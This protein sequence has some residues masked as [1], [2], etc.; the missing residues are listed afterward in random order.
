MKSFRRSRSMMYLRTSLSSVDDRDDNSVNEVLL[1]GSPSSTG[2]PPSIRRCG[3]L[4]VES[5]HKL[6]CSTGGSNNNTSRGEALMS[7]SDASIDHINS[8]SNRG[9]QMISVDP[10]TVYPSLNVDN[11]DLTKHFV[12]LQYPTRRCEDDA[13]DDA[14][15]APRR[16]LSPSRLQKFKSK[17]SPSQQQQQQHQQSQYTMGEMLMDHHDMVSPHEHMVPPVN[18]V[19]STQ[20]HR[21]DIPECVLIPRSNMNH[22]TTD[23]FLEDGSRCQNS[24]ENG[25]AGSPFYPTYYDDIPIPSNSR[26]SAHH[27]DLSE[28]QY[29]HNSKMHDH[30]VVLPLEN[31]P[32]RY[33]SSEKPLGFD[34]TF[35]HTFAMNNTDENGWN[36]TNETI[37]ESVPSRNVEYEFHES[38]ERHHVQKLDDHQRSR[39]STMYRS[40]SRK[41]DVSNVSRDFS[42]GSEGVPVTQRT[43]YLASPTEETTKMSSLSRKLQMDQRHSIALQASDTSFTTTKSGATQATSHSTSTGISRSSRKTQELIRRFERHGIQKTGHVSSIY[44]KGTIK[45]PS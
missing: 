8:H 19:T 40:N 17:S 14:L 7:Q 27:Y 28:E 32:T 12:T 37:P 26:S 22:E 2:K 29:G 36:G 13:S 41:S 21:S 31:M 15:T 44:D 39:H 43:Y 5:M 11:N 20:Q 33:T 10:L 4:F 9:L 25:T 30:D 35:Q 18:E 6:K 34:S 23:L 16:F 45:L 3:S 38:S 42:L 24:D 1:N